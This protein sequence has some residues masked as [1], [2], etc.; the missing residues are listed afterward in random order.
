TTIFTRCS[1]IESL[2]S[3]GFAGH[4]TRKPGR[5]QLSI[6]S[7]GHSPNLLRRAFPGAECDTARMI[8][9]VSSISGSLPAWR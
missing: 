4:Y 2:A 1:S 5:R 9:A 3:S 7:A 8:R 6:D